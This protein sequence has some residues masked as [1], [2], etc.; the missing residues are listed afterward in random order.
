MR[1]NKRL[2]LALLRR[3]RSWETV[4]VQF[5][6]LDFVF[7]AMAFRHGVEPHVVAVAYEIWPI[8]LITVVAWGSGGRYKKLGLWEYAGI[9]V[10]IAGI[11]VAVSAGNSVSISWLAQGVRGDGL[12]LLKGLGFPLLAGLA[13]GFTGFSWVICSKA[14]RSDH[15]RNQNK[16]GADIGAMLLVLLCLC[17]ALSSLQC[18]VLGMIFEGI[19]PHTVSVDILVYGLGIGGAG[20]GLAAVLWRLATTVSDHS[21]IHAISSLTP[22]VALVTFSM[23]GV[24]VGVDYAMLCLGTALTV[25]GN[26]AVVLHSYFTTI[27]A[28]IWERS[29]EQRTRTKLPVDQS[30]RTRK[31]AE[32]QEHVHMSPRRPEDV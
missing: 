13:T 19:G 5:S 17:N 29:I 27:A 16:D 26:A 9:A 23:L 11:Y 25:I 15:V 32:A 7:L 28:T 20:Y 4:L 18:A 1:L 21:G 6:Y 12:Q 2:L 10:S 14:F 30:T 8:L 24:L 31:S 22:V 3:Y